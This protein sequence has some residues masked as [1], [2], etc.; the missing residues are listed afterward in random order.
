MG[1]VAEFRAGVRKELPITLGVVPFG[2]I[3]G[4]L[5]VGAG[6]PP[7]AA[8]AMSSIVFA[9]SAQ[10]IGVQLIGVGT[11]IGLI[12]LTTSIVNL[13]HLLYGASLSPYVRRLSAGWRLLLPKG[14]R[15][16]WPALPHNPYRKGGEAEASEGRIVVVLPFSSDVCRYEM[17]LQILNGGSN[18]D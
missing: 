11:P 16:E 15:I 12:W 17:V 4:V 13:R 6:L 14:A 18:G 5:A 3:Y 2:T 9:G 8:Q 10:F 7:L 1:R